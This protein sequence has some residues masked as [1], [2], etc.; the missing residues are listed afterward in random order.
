VP[1]DPFGGAVNQPPYYVLA[2]PPG[3]T[4][5]SPDFQLTT[6]MVVGGA[7]NNLAA[8]ISAQS[9][10]GDGADYGKLTV[11]QVSGGTTIY[12]PGQVAN[13]LKST[14]VISKDITQLGQGQSEVIH[15]NLLTLPVGNSFLYVEPLYVESTNSA[16]S[17]PT[18]QR[19]LVRYGNGNQVGYGATLEAA[20]D[21]IRDKLP[22]GSSLGTLGQTSGNATPP[23]GGSSTSPTPTPTPTPTGTPTNTTGTSPPAAPTVKSLLAQ[24]ST[25]KTRLSAAYDTKDPVKI[26]QAQAAEQRIV[27]QLLALN[28]PASASNSPSK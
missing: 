20:L 17:F 19:V 18:L 9:D 8:Y 4:S 7:S 22:A 6:P 12:G 26:A 2:R 14:A 13:D 23:S 21:D 28:A 10:Y 16:S 25:A 15:G 27:D 5:N 11:L 24:L 3:G 1:T